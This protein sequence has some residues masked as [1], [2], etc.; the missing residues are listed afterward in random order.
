MKV[1][2]TKRATTLALT[3]AELRALARLVEGLERDRVRSPVSWLL[4]KKSDVQLYR[5]LAGV[6]AAFGA[7]RLFADDES[8]LDGVYQRTLE[9]VR[10]AR[11]AVR[12]K[13]G[14]GRVTV[15]A[16]TWREA[17]GL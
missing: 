1:T 5:Q 17:G 2:V 12:G 16:P 13:G 9:A 7:T 11:D 4:R 8:R 3:D 10:R 6:V 15:A 14:N